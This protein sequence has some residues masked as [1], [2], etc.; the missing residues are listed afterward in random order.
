M[1]GGAGG[2]RGRRVDLPPRAAQFRGAG[3]AKKRGRCGSGATGAAEKEPSVTHAQPWRAPG[4][5]SLVVLSAALLAL[6]GPARAGDF[7]NDVKRTFTTDIPHFFQDDIPCTFGGK[8][9]SGTKSSCQ[10]ASHPA[11]AHKAAAPKKKR[12]ATQPAARAP[13]SEASAGANAGAS[14]GSPAASSSAAPR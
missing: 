4:V 9:T 3:A 5:L 11:P 6:P 13:A 8:P 2:Q 10:G 12:R 14:A 7:P 1:H